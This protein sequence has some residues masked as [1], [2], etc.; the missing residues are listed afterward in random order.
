[1]PD[2]RCDSGFSRH[3]IEA[4]VEALALS[5]LAIA[6]VGLMRTV[7]SHIDSTRGLER[8]AAA[9]WVAENRLAELE[10]DPAR[11]RASRSR[12]WASAMARRGGA[13]PHRRSRDRA[14]ADRTCSRPTERRR[15]H[16]STASWTDARDDRPQP[17]RPRQAR[18]TL[19]LLTG[20]VVVSVA[21]AL[22]GLTWRIAGH[23]GTG[24]ITVP[25]GRSGPAVPARYRRRHRA[26]P[27]RQGRA[28]RCE[29]ADRPAAS[30]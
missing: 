10:L 9:M 20:A 25:S 8:R 6:T 21:F 30:S 22:A 2:A 11:A 24:A 13:P 5:V 23:A 28:R 27:V 4:M 26:R 15:L 18:T 7:E 3:L 1:M 19:D 14:R 16:R 17:S 29:P 12:C